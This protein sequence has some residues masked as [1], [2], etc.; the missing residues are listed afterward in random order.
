MNVQAAGSSHYQSNQQ[1]MENRLDLTD[2]L[3]HETL[4]LKE[5]SEGQLV[6]HLNQNEFHL[7]VSSTVM[8]TIHLSSLN[9]SGIV[10]FRWEQS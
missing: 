3:M 5:Y 8:S 4:S 9:S 6:C 10:R 2:A 7:C 1:V